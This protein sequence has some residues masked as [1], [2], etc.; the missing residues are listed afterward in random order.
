MASIYLPGPPQLPLIKSAGT[1]DL[2]GSLRSSLRTPVASIQSLTSPLE[3]TG[4]NWRAIEASEFLA[5][6][7]AAYEQDRMRNKFSRYVS[8]GED[9]SIESMLRRAPKE[10]KK[11]RKRVERA[12]RLAGTGLFRNAAQILGLKQQNLY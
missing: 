1:E 2:S 11:N 10:A 9:R 7:G 3:I 12:K 8:R 4:I 5:A 6:I